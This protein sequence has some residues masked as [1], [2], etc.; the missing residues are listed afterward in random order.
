MS[1]FFAQ[2]IILF[3]PVGIKKPKSRLFHLNGLGIYMYLVIK[4]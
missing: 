2:K 3:S 1:I 4:L